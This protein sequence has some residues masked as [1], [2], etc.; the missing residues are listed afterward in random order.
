MNSHL[1]VVGWNVKD[2]GLADS[3]ESIL[4]KQQKKNLMS[5]SKLINEKNPN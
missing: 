3:N 2:I 4:E 1:S 5:M